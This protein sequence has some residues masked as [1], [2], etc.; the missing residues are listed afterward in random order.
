MANAKYSHAIISS[1]T[2]NIQTYPF[3]LNCSIILAAESIGTAK[4]KP[5][6]AATF[7]ILT[8]TISPS[9]LTR[10]PPEFPYNTQ[11]EAKN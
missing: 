3:F 2:H 1:W 4:L 9:I 7:I 10:G 11:A 8:P 5:S 6:A